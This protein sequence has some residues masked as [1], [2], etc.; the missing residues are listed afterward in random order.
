M[1]GVRDGPLPIS[2][3]DCDRRSCLW[4]TQISIVSFLVWATIKEGVKRALATCPRLTETAG[5]K[6]NVYN[7]LVTQGAYSSKKGRSIRG[8]WRIMSKQNHRS[9]TFN[10]RKPYSKTNETLHSRYG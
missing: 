10:Q 9:K 3:L 4:R 8:G 6:L 2:E 1:P 5:V 7:R